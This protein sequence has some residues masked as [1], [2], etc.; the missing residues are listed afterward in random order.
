VAGI[1]VRVHVTFALLL[2]LVAVGSATPGGPG[3]V[4]GVA[5]IVAIFACVV[6][7]ELAHSLVAR[8]HDIAVTEIDLLPFGG[9]SKMAQVPDDP[10]VEV[11]IAIAGPLASFALAAASSLGAVALGVDLWPPV[12]DRGSILVRLAWAN[13]LLAGFNLLPALPLDGGR[14]FRALLEQR[15]GRDRAT[16]ISAQVARG[17]SVVMVAAGVLVNPW[18]VV[19][20]AVVMVG[21]AAEEAAVG[22]HDRIKD[23]RVADV[24]VRDPEV[25]LAD[26]PAG[27]LARRLAAGS[28]RAFPV[29]TPDRRYLGLTSL[30]EL[31]R[32]GPGRCAGE[33]TAPGA[34]TLAP[35]DLVED[36]GLL[37]GRAATAA[38]LAGGRVVGLA[39]DELADRAVRRRLGVPVRSL[40]PPPPPPPPTR[41]VS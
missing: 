18:L 2:G 20:G 15:I 28:Q 12:L 34:P 26:A 8:R 35:D 32:A 39:T 37:D 16:H 3:V 23:L 5:W 31:A 6:V 30:D 4:E 19:I 33:L 40:H 36:S 1:E 17:L 27:P 29:V 25:L 10:G 41:R 13:L 22:I 14:V 11:R 38:V 7:H 24:M 9:L 21:S